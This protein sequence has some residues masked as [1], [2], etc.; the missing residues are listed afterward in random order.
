MIYASIQFK[1]FPDDSSLCHVD[2]KNKNKK[3]NQLSSQL[4]HT[5]TCL[6]KNVYLNFQW[7]LLTEAKKVK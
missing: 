7:K 5:K 2:I 6:Y 4:K 3:P 1:L